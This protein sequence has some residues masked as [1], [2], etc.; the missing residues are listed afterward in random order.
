MQC[1]VFLALSFARSTFEQ[2]LRKKAQPLLSEEVSFNWLVDAPIE[3]KRSR[4]IFCRVSYAGISILAILRE[5]LH[6]DSVFPI[7]LAC[8]R[9]L[10][11]EITFV[12]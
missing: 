10:G 6:F 4:L 11:S 5:F 12:F 1:F 9:N 7:N 2:K 8:L 3:S